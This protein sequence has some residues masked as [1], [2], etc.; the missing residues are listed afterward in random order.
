[1][2]HRRRGISASVRLTAATVLAVIGVVV[3]LHAPSLGSVCPAV[4]PAPAWCTSDSRPLWSGIGLVAIAASYVTVLVATLAFRR[5]PR[6]ESGGLASLTRAAGALIGVW[7]LVFAVAA[8]FSGGFAIDVPGLA[9]AA[10]ASLAVI[11]LTVLLAQ[12]VRQPGLPLNR[13]SRT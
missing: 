4:Y 9:L 7:T 8:T 5:Q 6:A 3:L 12:P 11:A 1:M 10:C 2:D 13:G